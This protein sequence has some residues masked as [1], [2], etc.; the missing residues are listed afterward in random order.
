MKLM[1]KKIL[2]T[3]EILLCRFLVITFSVLII[4]DPFFKKIERRFEE[5]KKRREKNIYLFLFY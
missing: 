4:S 1:T 2:S 3:F 5:E